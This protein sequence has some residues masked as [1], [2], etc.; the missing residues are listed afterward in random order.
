M[1]NWGGTA[2]TCSVVDTGTGREAHPGRSTSSNG[3]TKGRL[4]IGLICDNTRPGKAHD[5]EP[6]AGLSVIVPGEFPKPHCM[7][8][9]M[10]IKS[11]AA[12]ELEERISING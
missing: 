7:G 12:G 6:D 5:E 11:S 9:A 10:G 1:R 8:D 3:E 4:V 2:W